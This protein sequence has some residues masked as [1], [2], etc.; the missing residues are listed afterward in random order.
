MQHTNNNGT[1]TTADALELNTIGDA[2][3]AEWYPHHRPGDPVPAHLPLH[4][5]READ[6]LALRH[7]MAAARRRGR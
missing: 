7:R 3:F 6:E 2:I 4:V 1:F 5:Q